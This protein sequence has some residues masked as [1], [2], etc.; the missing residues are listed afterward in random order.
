MNINKIIKI[1]F[2]PICIISVHCFQ[3]FVNKQHKDFV[4][5]QHKDFV[6]KPYKDFIYFKSAIKKNDKKKIWEYLNNKNFN[7]YKFNEECWRG[8]IIYESVIYNNDVEI[9]KKLLDNE[10]L[11]VFHYCM[12]E[13]IYLMEKGYINILKLLIYHPKVKMHRT[14]LYYAISFDLFNIIDILCR[15]LEF[16]DILKKYNLL[17]YDLSEEYCL[18]KFDKNIQLNN[19]FR[20][21]HFTFKNNL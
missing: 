2:I 18:K 21:C 7:P 14:I 8:S 5:K 19:H 1:I 4:Y 12:F 13:M 3:Y 9:I 17:I 11:K 16:K 15:N 6:H 20:L 10:N